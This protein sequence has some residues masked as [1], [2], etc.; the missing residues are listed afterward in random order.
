MDLNV[1][2]SHKPEVVTFAIFKIVNSFVQARFANACKQKDLQKRQEALSF[3]V[4]IFDR[5]HL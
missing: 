5:L 4:D 1:Q 2:F 3:L